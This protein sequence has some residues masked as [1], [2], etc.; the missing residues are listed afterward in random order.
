ML[1]DVVRPSML[2]LVLRLPRSQV[3]RSEVALGSSIPGDIL[4]LETV[5]TRILPTISQ[6]PKNGR[7][8]KR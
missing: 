1:E 7:T 8:Q 4:D 5:N 3:S 6:A 2:R